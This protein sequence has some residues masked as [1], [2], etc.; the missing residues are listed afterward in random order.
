MD[1]CQE[2]GIVLVNILVVQILI[3]HNV[4][5]LFAKEETMDAQE[6]ASGD[7]EFT[8]LIQTSA[9]LHCIVE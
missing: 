1:G 7:L 2:D 8:H 4:L 6:E 9:T 5:I 3:K